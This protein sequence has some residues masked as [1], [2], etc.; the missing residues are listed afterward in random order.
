MSSYATRESAGRESPSR[1]NAFEASFDQFK[2]KRRRTFSGR[3]KYFSNVKQFFNGCKSRVRG[4]KE[5]Y[6]EHACIG[7]TLYK[8]LK[9]L[10]EDQNIK[11]ESRLVLI[12]WASISCFLNAHNRKFIKELLNSGR[13][14]IYF[15]GYII[16]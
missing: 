13:L 4:L 10:T 16:L 2:N 3:G 9:L 5:R 8:L 7:S 6:E 12:E 14:Y 15:N 1:S 11:F